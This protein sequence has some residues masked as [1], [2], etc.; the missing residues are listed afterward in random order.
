MDILKHIAASKCIRKGDS[1][2]RSTIPKGT[3]PVKSTGNVLDSKQVLIEM[4]LL[5]LKFASQAI[6]EKSI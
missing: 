2:W 4:K 3:P 1:K 5:G 6:I